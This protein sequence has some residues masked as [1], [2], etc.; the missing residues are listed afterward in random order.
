MKNNNQENSNENNDQGNSFRKDWLPDIRK[1]WIPAIITGIFGGFIIAILVPWANSVFERQRLYQE[2]K[3]RLLESTAE[4]FTGVVAKTGK[5]RALEAAISSAKM[6][7]DKKNALSIEKHSELE[8]YVDKRAKELR[9][10]EVELY[11][12]IQKL[13]ANFALIELF[14]DKQ[15]KNAID[16]FKVWYEAQKDKPIQAKDLSIHSNNLIRAMVKEME[17]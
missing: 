17:K 2:R 3:T 15:A 14:F 8:K 7:L 13:I 12:L 11:N 10:T 5:I 9:E 4:L 16:D 6:D 1:T